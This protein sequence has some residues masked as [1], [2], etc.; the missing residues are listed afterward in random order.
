MTKEREKKRAENNEIK[1]SERRKSVTDM[2]TDKDMP[3]IA[4]R[5]GKKV[6]G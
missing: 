1:R 2:D 5:A 3:V 4:D 6:N